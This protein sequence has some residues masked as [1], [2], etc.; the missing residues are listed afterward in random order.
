M[1]SVCASAEGLAGLGASGQPLSMVTLPDAPRP[2]LAECA[3]CIPCFTGFPQ[4][5]HDH[6]TQL[7]LLCS[8]TTTSTTPTED[9]GPP[10][11]ALRYPAGSVGDRRVRWRLALDSA[12][13]CKIDE[14]IALSKAVCG[15]SSDDDG[16]AASQGVLVSSRLQART[17]RAYDELAAIEDAIARIDDGTYG[18]CAGCDRAMSDEWLAAQPGARYC[19]DC[20]LRLVSWQ[21]PDLPHAQPSA[22]VQRAR[23]KPGAGIRRQRS[24]P[25]RPASVD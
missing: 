4:Q 20:S 5:A 23:P 11:Q 19:P 14:V 25:T 16:S 10:E 21:Q 18:M 7:W 17:E 9:L 1:P 8:M 22:P 6:R 15:L 24:R 2:R 13:Q 12:W 3:R